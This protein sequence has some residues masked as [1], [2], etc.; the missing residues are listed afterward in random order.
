MW[1]KRITYAFSNGLRILL[2]VVHF[3]VINVLTYDKRTHYSATRKQ[4]SG[5]MNNMTGI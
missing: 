3:V 2:V 4:A 1:A 5:L